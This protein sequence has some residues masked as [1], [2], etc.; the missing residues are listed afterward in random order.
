M[1]IIHLKLNTQSDVRIKKRGY[2]K[3]FTVPT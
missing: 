3:G 1:E 2:K